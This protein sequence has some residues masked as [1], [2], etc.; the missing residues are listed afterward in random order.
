M[1]DTS[2]FLWELDRDKPK[3]YAVLMYDAFGKMGSDVDGGNTNRPGSR[4]E[5]QSVRGPVFSG[6]YCQAFFQQDRVLYFVGICVPDSCGEEE[7]QILVHNETFKLGHTALISPFPP[8]LVPQST[9][10]TLRTKCVSNIPTPDP[11]D[12]TCLFVCSLM[13]A[14]PLAATLFTAIIRRQRH[15]EVSP[16]VESSL[17]AGSSLYG[18]LMSRD[19]SSNE[20]DN[21][22]TL[23]NTTHNVHLTPNEMDNSSSQEENNSIRHKL[24]SPGDCVY[25]C[26]QA[27]SLQN[28]TQG[29]LSTSSHVSY[30]SLNGIRVLTLL[31]IIYGHTMLSSKMFH[32]DNNQRWRKTVLKNPLH[33]FTLNGPF[34]LPVD[35]F[36][37]IGG[38][39]SARSLLCSIHKAE[40]KM[41]PSVV[42]NFLFRRFKRIQPLHLFIICLCIGLFSL[43]PKGSYWFK[44]H[45][46]V[47]DCK[48]YWWANLLLI[49]N[50]FTTHKACL[51]WMWYLGVDFQNYLITPLLVYLYRRNRAVLATVATSLLLMSITTSAV[52]TA[53]LHLP[54]G[55]PQMQSLDDY[56]QYYYAQPFTRCAPF[57]MGIL[58]GIYMT[59]SKDQV[60][61]H[62]W[63]AALGWFSCLSGMALVFVLGYILQDVPPRPSVPHALY[64]GLH[65]PLWALAVAWIILACEEGYGGFIKSLLSHGWWIPVSNISFAC[66]MIHPFFL[67]LYDDTQD[68]PFHYTYMN[69]MYLFFGH[70][71]P[72]LVIGYVLT[73][74][75]EKPFLLLKGRNSVTIDNVTID[76]VTINNLTIDNVTIDNVTI[77]NVTIDNVTIDSVTIDSVTIDNVTIDNVTIDNVTINNLTIDNVTIDNVTI[78]NVTIDNVTID[79]VTINNVTI[80][81]VTIDSVTIDSVTIDNV[82]IDNVTID[83]VTINN[84]TIDNVTIDNVTIDNVTINNLT[85][86][87]VTIDNVTIDNVTIDSV[88]IDSVTIDNVTIDNVTIDNVTI[89]NLT[90]DNVTIDNVT[91][92]NVTIDNV[93]I[94]NVT[95]DNVT[96]NNLTIDNVTI[97]NVTIDNVTIDNVTIDNVTIDNVTINNVT[98]DNVTID[99]VTINNLTIDSVTIDNVTIDNVTIN[100]LTID[101]VT[102]DN[103][104]IDNVTI[105]NLTIDNVTIDNVTIDNVTINNLTI[106][107]VTID[108][109]TIDNVTI[110]NVTINNLTI[111]SVTIDSVTIDNVTID[112]VTIDNVAL[113]I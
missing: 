2:T 88:T 50:F 25:W 112:N 9:H 37:L 39:L 67:T 59:T 103:V 98:I 12:I 40:D 86:D 15:R 4:E 106:D 27:F 30:S 95:I 113:P 21:C 62:Q 45:H 97:D 10:T 66:Y 18:T 104:T 101:N 11:G 69:F 7:V 22:L 89:N 16:G 63:Q 70:L 71:V 52:I 78:D 73:V 1:Q 28:T 90:I 3:Q 53:V 5:C 82:T 6:Q 23:S 19:G 96:I 74:L 92:D 68:T 8:I 42:G 109:L 76:N 17:D 51:P 102:I 80:D 47:V 77:N 81:N 32:M 38:L 87:N 34:F 20:G 105:N 14:I 24:C 72:T 64:Q 100:N 108:N 54:V 107:S 79:N 110:D 26:L 58:M 93:T 60:L 46:T 91:I 57:V 43:V 33:V 13:V 83:N 61:K 99:N 36:L 111:D 75:V 84:L 35:T 85:I 44:V 65:R 56:F 94:D 41:S 49:N 29:V 31:W 48:M 55:L